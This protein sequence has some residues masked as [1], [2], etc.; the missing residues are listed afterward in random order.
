MTASYHEQQSE[1]LYPQNGRSTQTTGL[2]SERLTPIAFSH[3][4]EFRSEGVARRKTVRRWRD[5]PVLLHPGTQ[6]EA[7]FQ[8]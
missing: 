7:Y 4:F 2:V 5:V 3:P 8:Y 1:N 6:Q